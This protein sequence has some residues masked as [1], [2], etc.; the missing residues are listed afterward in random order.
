MVR[1]KASK[2]IDIFSSIFLEITLT[3]VWLSKHLQFRSNIMLGC[4]SGIS[5]IK[6]VRI[7]SW[8]S[9]NPVSTF[10][11]FWD[12]FGQFIKIKSMEEGFYGFL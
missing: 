5:D 1:L 10:D 4:C 9:D 2:S 8:K 7:S 6:R 3:N 12:K 11:K